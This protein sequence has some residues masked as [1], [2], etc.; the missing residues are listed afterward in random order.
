MVEIRECRTINP[1]G[2][3]SCYINLSLPECYRWDICGARTYHN[4]YSSWQPQVSSVPF[5]SILKDAAA[6]GAASGHEL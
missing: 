4:L 1:W 2:L 3:S 6:G 5:E